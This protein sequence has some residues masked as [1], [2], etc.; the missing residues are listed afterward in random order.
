MA[1]RRPGDKPLS[2][3]MMVSLPTHICVTRPQWVD[4]FYSIH[5][6]FCKLLC[7]WG[8]SCAIMGRAGCLH[9]C[10]YD[11][12]EAPAKDNEISQHPLLG[13]QDLRLC[14]NDHTGRIVMK[15]AKLTQKVD[16]IHDH[17]KIINPEIKWRESLFVFVRTFIAFHFS[18]QSDASS[19]SATKSQQNVLM[20]SSLKAVKLEFESLFQ[21]VKHRMVQYE[22]GMLILDQNYI[23]CGHSV[24]TVISPIERNSL[25]C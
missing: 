8:G 19:L 22:D 21:T 3:P 1:W 18:S 10:C 9:H 24:V 25:G 12:N 5:F 23:F 14:W 17:V 16:K 20:H 2:E 15:L 7:G 13:A 11:Q 4:L 6:L